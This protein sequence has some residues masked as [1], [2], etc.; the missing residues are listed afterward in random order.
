[1]PCAPCSR[2]RQ[3]GKTGAPSWRSSRRVPDLHSEDDWFLVGIITAPFG[4]RGEVRVEVVT[5]FS[6]YFRRRRTLYTGPEKKPVK[7]ERAH[8]RGKGGLALKLAGYDTPEQAETLRREQLYVPRSEA[9]PLPAGRYY[10]D[11]VIGLEAR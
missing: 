3:R 5:E 6:T 9:V 7:V 8:G 11:D 10:V 1:M 2:H 4:V